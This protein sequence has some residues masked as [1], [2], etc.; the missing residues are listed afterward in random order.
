VYPRRACAIPLTFKA[1]IRPSR[2][3]AFER[4][5]RL[6]FDCAT[7]SAP[8]KLCS[9]NKLQEPLYITTWI[10]T[11]WIERLRLKATSDNIGRA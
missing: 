3:Q 8:R 9:F 1:L 5:V 10:L 2:S 4:V 6:V 7:L 11:G